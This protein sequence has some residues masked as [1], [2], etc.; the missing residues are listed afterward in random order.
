MNG[1]LVL[2]VRV[3]CQG[4]LF[5]DM[6]RNINQYDLVKLLNQ[7]V[8]IQFQEV[9]GIQF[10]I[11][12]MLEVDIKGFLKDEFCVNSQKYQVNDMMID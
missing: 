2:L 5:M 10:V 1:G 4:V 9:L 3:D 6:V 12:K 7:Y 8:K 11:G